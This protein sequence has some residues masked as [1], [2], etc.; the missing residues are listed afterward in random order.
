M[1]PEHKRTCE[2][3][4]TYYKSSDCPV[5]PVCERQKQTDGFMSVIAAPARR[6]LDRHG[7]KTTQQLSKCSKQELMNLHG[8]GPNA[9]NKLEIYLK[10]YHL[11]FKT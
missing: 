5:C 6:A 9:I 1:S 4:H 7:I 3:G 10:Q 2:K 11:E 8:M